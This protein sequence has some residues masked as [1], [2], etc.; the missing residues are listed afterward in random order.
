M[1][2]QWSN[3]HTQILWRK[4]VYIH[5]LET[6]QS[7]ICWFD[8]EAVR[9]TQKNGLIWFRQFSIVFSVLM[10]DY[11]N[12]W[13]LFRSSFY[14]HK[15]LM[16]WCITS[17]W[18]FHDDFLLYDGRFDSHICWLSWLMLIRRGMLEKFLVMIHG[19]YT[20]D[21]CGKIMQFLIRWWCYGHRWWIW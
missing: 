3:F 10:V 5:E 4:V 11:Y 9:Q 14:P 2:F 19:W 6:A 21:S 13:M 7:H 1:K 12:L 8:E 16:T 15:F 20:K 17:W 18:W